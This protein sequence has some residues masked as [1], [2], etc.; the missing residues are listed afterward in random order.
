MATE[1]AF[2][3][4]RISGCAAKPRR[5]SLLYVRK[6]FY[7]LLSLVLSRY[8]SAVDLTIG[9]VPKVDYSE[10]VVLT[11]STAPVGD[12]LPS[13]IE[14]PIFWLDASDT[15]DWTIAADGKVTEVPSK[16]GSRKLTTD[17]TTGHFKGWPNTSTSNQGWY[18]IVPSSPRMITDETELAKGVSLD[19]GIRSSSSSTG[20]RAMV[21]D[22]VTV[23]ADATSASNLLVNIG[24]VVMVV[25]PNVASAY[26]PLGGGFGNVSHSGDSWLRNTDS[27]ETGSATEDSLAAAMFRLGDGYAPS[28]ACFAVIRHDGQPTSARDMGWMGSWEVLSFMP[29]A[30]DLRATG[31]GVAR[32]TAYGYGY[33]GGFRVA[34]MLIFGSLLPKSDVERI[35]A[36]LQKKWFGQAPAATGGNAQIGW[37]HVSKKEATACTVTANVGEGDTLTVDRLQGGRYDGALVKNGAGTLAVKNTAGFGGPVTLNGGTLAFPARAVPTLA[38][39][40]SDAYAH[41]DASDLSTVTYD[42][43]T[44]TVSQ[45]TNTTARTLAGMP[46]GLCQSDASKRPTLRKDALGSGLNILDFGAVASGPFLSFTSLSDGTVRTVDKVATVVGVIGAQNS[47]GGG[48]LFGYPGNTASSAGGWNRNAGW[49][50]WGSTLLSPTC[51]IE[52][53]STEPIYATNDLIVIDGV[54]AP[55]DSGYRHPGYQVAAIRMPGA[56]ARRLASSSIGGGHTGGMR[57]G[58]LF[59]FRRILTELEMRDITAYLENKW[60][61]RT[62]PGYRAAVTNIPQLAKVSVEAASSIDVPSESTV[63]LGALTGTDVG[64]LTKTGAGTLAVEQLDTTGAVA[65]AEGTLKIVAKNDPGA[66]LCQV[67]AV[68]SL[69]LDACDTNRMDLSVSGDDTRVNDWYSQ[70][71]SGYAWSNSRSPYLRLNAFGPGLNAVDF[72]DSYSSTSPYLL[73][74]TSRDSVRSVF[75]VWQT[76]TKSSPLLGS[77]KTL[78][79][80]AATQCE[81]YDFIRETTTGALLAGKT[82]QYTN[83]DSVYTNGVLSSYRYTP[84]ELPCHLVELHLKTGFH[85]SSLT[86]DRSH[87]SA[88]GQKLGEIIIY[89]RKLTEREKVATR[90]Y[91]MRKWFGKTDEELTPLPDP[92]P[93]VHNIGSLTVAQGATVQLSGTVSIA[94]LCVDGGA[95]APAFSVD[96]TFAIAEGQVV[97]LSHPELLPAG[98]NFTVPI[99]SAAAFTGSDRANLK[100]AVINGLPDGRPAKLTVEGGMLVLDFR[101]K[102][103]VISFR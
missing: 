63:R 41:F 89:E 76:A 84:Q 40:P 95:T 62:S 7:V 31:L 52:A 9:D 83:V 80:E 26:F 91:L 72:G 22:A 11:T 45:W 1:M 43:E 66:N 10:S 33:A 13:G 18:Y 57:V 4:K 19:F 85:A 8:A 69:H 61:G 50:S 28:N 96:G 86:T 102:S 75:A 21:F 5:G 79:P 49:C 14:D 97:T 99:L 47:G 17:L 74:D 55:H 88:G 53:D 29:K 65:V 36:Y 51:L 58:E 67:A 39:L 59:I 48:H 71:G 60:F 94:E 38:D 68:A 23:P 103:L 24:T 101:L 3:G 15:N 64:T 35:E 37:L 20:R 6:S 2:D 93:V 44:L 34:E 12:T 92:E 78:L 46:F 25:K 54:R 73:L 87:A 81:P 90:N 16:V 100:T 42:E 56:I 98:A 82:F 32:E 30:A 70:S 77:C 27:T